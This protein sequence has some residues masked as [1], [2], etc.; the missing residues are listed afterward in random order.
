MI[1]FLSSSAQAQYPQD[2]ATA[3]TSDTTVETG[4]R[5]TIG[6]E[7]WDPGSRV[8]LRWPS[9]TLGNAQVDRR[10]NFSTTV[11]VPQD[12]PGGERFVSVVGT[13][14]GGEPTEIGI[15][16]LV[17]GEPA[18]ADE[19]SFTGVNIGLWLLGAVGLFLVG[20]LA[21]LGVRRRTSTPG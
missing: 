4:Q 14:V 20:I 11:T 8:E 16:M 12:T 15:R 2:A 3:G 7:G 10:G 13:S 6:G 19:V 17:G 21:A 18:S 5:V 1:F 9:A